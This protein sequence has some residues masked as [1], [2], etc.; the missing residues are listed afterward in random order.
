M[1]KD[2]AAVRLGKKGA[3]KRNALLTAEQRR[4]IAQHAA[5]C[6]WRSSGACF[7]LRVK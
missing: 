2:P 7:S 4:K 3:A 1:K 5:N 6:R